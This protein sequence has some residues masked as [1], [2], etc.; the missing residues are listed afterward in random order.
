M[1]TLDEASNAAFHAAVEPLRSA[2]L[3]FTAKTAE[4]RERAGSTPFTNSQGMSELAGQARY[5][6]NDAWGEAPIEE[7]ITSSCLLLAVAEDLI[8]SLGR[9]YDGGLPPV[10]GHL[11]LTRAVLEAS[12]RAA[13]LADPT[14]GGKIRV[15][16][17]IS[18]RLFSINEA[19]RLP[20]APSTDARRDAVIDEARR[21]GF[22]V[23]EPK[24][25][26]TAYSLEAARPGNTQAVRR[27]F[28]RNQ[29]FGEMIYGYYCAVA[30][31][32]I[33]GLAKNLIADVDQR[34]GVRQGFVTVGFGSNSGDALN[35]LSVAG[36]GYMEG[37][38]RLVEL[39]GW[40]TDDWRKTT[41]NF[42]RMRQA[43]ANQP[44]QEPTSR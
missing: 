20:G 18:E 5:A 3:D 1:T 10:F 32:T 2:L 7:A 22:V 26:G 24:R 16:R 33:Y 27:L 6:G 38:F 9:L 43:L 14:I 31:S 19:G 30:H 35:T 4:L 44:A 42:I 21:L 29:D 28:S 41:K 17:V 13:W 34:R 23:V 11:V 40:A 12:A 25:R 36:L 8:R 39:C 15:A 37:A